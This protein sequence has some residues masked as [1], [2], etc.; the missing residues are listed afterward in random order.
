[1]SNFLAIATVT[2]AL[3]QILQD[4]VK[5]AVGGATVGFNRPNGSGGAA[6]AEV[7]VYLYEVT[8]NAAY[9]NADV[10]TRRSD[11]SL[12]QRPQAALDLHYLFTFH[13]DDSKLEPQRMLGAVVST[14]QSQPLLSTQNIKAAALHFGFLAG[15]GLD[16]Q[17]ER[18]KFAPTSLSLDEFT[19]L[20]SAFFQ[21]EY[22]L[23]AAYQASLVLIESDVTPQE[24][25]P[26][27][28]RNVYALPFRMPTVTRVV[29]QAGPNVPILP[30]S[31]LVVQGTRLLAPLTLVQV[32]SAV[33]TPT[34]VTDRAII[35]PVP[36]GLAAGIQGLQVIQQSLIGTPP[37]PHSGVESNVVPF[38]LHPV[39]GSTTPTASLVSV[40]VTPAVQQGQRATL[41][42]NEATTPPP[43]A[44]PAA[45]SFS[46][47]PLDIASS[48]LNFA[49]S[50]VRGGGTMYFIRVSVDGAESPLVLD[51]SNPA[52]GPTV[53]IP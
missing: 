12:V 35:L 38:V 45:Y 36:A 7:D 51:P 9:R 3:Q 32:G 27:T 11:S 4:P 10:P 46:L 5:N 44:G 52:F 1:M 26:V 25:P 2:A 17:V 47:P 37:Q 8:P 40:T 48:T 29:S 41:L 23:S 33:A 16:T 28:S 43:P 19:K 6:N 14:L 18:V 13:G 31:T 15:S 20:W 42:L 39:I 34:T 53:T 30:T 22:R 24:G 49:I 21:V 50:N